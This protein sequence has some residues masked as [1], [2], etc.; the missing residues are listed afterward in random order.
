MRFKHLMKLKIAATAHQSVKLLYTCTTTVSSSTSN[1]GFA[2][3]NVFYE[4]L[5]LETRETSDLYTA[6]S[7]ISDM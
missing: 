1:D 5:V 4:T 3:V 6:W 7:L 2:H